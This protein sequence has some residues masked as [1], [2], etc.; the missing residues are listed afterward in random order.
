MVR[1]L[2]AKIGQEEIFRPTTGKWSLFDISNDNGLR[3]IDFDASINMIIRST[4]FPN[5]NMHQ[6]TWQSPDGVTKK[7]IDH[8]M[9]DGRHASGIIDARSC[10]GVNCDTDHFLV[11]FKYWQRISSYRRIP[12]ARKEK[13][14][15]GKLKDEKTL[16]KYHE[17]IGELLEKAKEQQMSQS[18]ERWL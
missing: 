3:A 9:I 13:Y 5:K 11:R 17:G 14:D 15:V 1:D 6:E 7:Q 4:Y 10:R 18:E 12:G 8:V 16:K 2:N